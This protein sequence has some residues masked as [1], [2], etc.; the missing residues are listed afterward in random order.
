MIP[1]IKNEDT[2][3]CVTSNV[4]YGGLLSPNQKHEERNKLSMWKPYPLYTETP[5]SLSDANTVI[6]E[7]QLMFL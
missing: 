3:L 5:K 7:R 1:E 4:G 6:T 2:F